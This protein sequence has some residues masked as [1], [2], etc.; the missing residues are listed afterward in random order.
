MLAGGSAR[1]ERGPGVRL[2]S[3]FL[4]GVSSHYSL[5]FVAVPLMVAAVAVVACLVLGR[6]AARV[7]A[8]NPRRLAQHRGDDGERPRAKRGA[9][10]DLALALSD[11]G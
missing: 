5:T 7:S 1:A 3:A 2:L 11:A 9:D 4:Y 6:R 10:A 8:D